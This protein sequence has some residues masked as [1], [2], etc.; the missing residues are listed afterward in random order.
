MAHGKIEIRRWDVIDI[1]YYEQDEK[2]VEDLVEELKTKGWDDP[3]WGEAGNRDYEGSVQ[4]IK[5][6]RIKTKSIKP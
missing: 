1:F 3:Q 5:N 4:M 6:H 2:A